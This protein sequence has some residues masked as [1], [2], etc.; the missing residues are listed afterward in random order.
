MPG[1]HLDLSS[2]G[3]SGGERGRQADRPQVRRREVHLLRHLHARLHQP[4]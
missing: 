4:R 1:E 2:D 3:P